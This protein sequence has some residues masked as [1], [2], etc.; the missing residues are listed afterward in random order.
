MRRVLRGKTAAQYSKAMKT[1]RRFLF[2]SFIGALPLIVG[3]SLY[4]APLTWFPGPPLIE[5]VSEAAT[6]A[7]GGFGN[8]L[9]G[10]NGI[11]FPFPIGLVATNSSWTIFPALSDTSSIAGGAAG[12]GDP[13]LFFGGTDGT[14]SSSAAINYSPSGDAVTA[15]PSMNAARS[16]LGYVSAGGDAYA[17]GGLDEN[18]APLASAER[19][20]TEGG[21]SWTLVASLPTPLYNFPAAYDGHN[22]IYVFGGRT[23]ATQGAETAAVFRYSISANTWTTVASMPVA[24]A[25]HAAAFGPDGKIYVV[26]GVSAGVTLDVV[27]IYS[28]G[29]DSWAISTPLPQALSATAMG[30]DSLGRLIIM[31]GIDANGYDVTNVWRSQQLLLPD[32][33]PAFTQFPATNG[34]YQTLYSSSIVATGAPPP[35]YTLV[36][37][38]T[39]MSVD[40]YSGAITWTPQGSQVGSNSATIRAT[41]YS[42]S[43]DWTFNIT[44]APPPPTTPTNLTVVSVT[45]TSVTLSWAP[46]NPLTPP[47]TFTIYQVTSTI[48]GGRIYTKMGTSSTNSVTLT[49]LQRAHT[50]SLVVNASASG[51]PTTGY[52]QQLAVTTTSPQPPPNVHLTDLTST[53]FSLAWDPSPGPAQNPA[54]STVT[55]YTI[56]QF[57]PGGTFIPKVTGITNTSG[58][59]TGLVPGSAAYWTVQAFDAQGFAAVGYTLITVSNPVPVGATLSGGA[60]LS[61]GNFQFSVQEGGAVVQT[62]LVQAN[63]DLSNPNG[64]VQIGSVLPASSL[65]TFTDT[66]ASLYPKRFYRVLSP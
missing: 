9:I 45:D 14:T 38:P 43:V 41:N 37:G 5:P 1:K 39:G 17:I 58:I 34:A 31:G 11:Y 47:V 27:Q 4:A 24:A 66:N 62:V 20:S 19:V 26:G 22:Y 60:S 59:V 65:F 33:P 7:S 15:F 25:G 30:V 54:F 50:Y 57:I 23:N 2:G 3:I 6:T 28:P 32:S 51:F 46:E 8:I 49:G 53:T 12:N 61:K 35:Y 52:S 13:I 55:S 36:S 64:W 18:G 21:G 44:V 40:F 29:S 48:H 10:G 56:S 16:Y 42:G 63:T